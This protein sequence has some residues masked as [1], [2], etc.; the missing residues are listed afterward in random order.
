MTYS[1][2]ASANHF[3]CHFLAVFE[4]IAEEASERKIEV[5]DELFV[6]IMDFSEAERSGF[7]KAF[8]TFWELRGDSR[9]G[10]ELRVSAEKLLKGCLEHFR[11]AVTRVGRIHSVIPPEHGDEFKLRA[12]KLPKVQNSAEFRSHAALLVRDFPK[13]ASWM[14]WW[15]R[16]SHA[17]ML[18]ESERA[19]DIDI[20]E[21]MPSTT[22]AEESLHWKLYSACGRDHEFL[23]G[24]YALQGVTAYYERIYEAEQTGTPIRY[25][26]S[27]PW[28]KTAAK[29]GR[30]KP[31]RAPDIA[32]T[33]RKSKSDGRPP[34]TVKELVITPAKKKKK[35]TDP[36]F[37]NPSYPWN[38]NSCWL[39]TSLQILF[40]AL[41]RSPDEYYA[42]QEMYNKPGSERSLL[43]TIFDKLLERYEAEGST[44][45]LTTPKLRLHRD[46]I[47]QSLKSEKIIKTISAFQS[48][49]VW[50]TE[51]TRTEEVGG[52][53]RFAMAFTKHSV[54]IHECTGCKDTGGRHIQ[55][56]QAPISR[57]ILQAGEADHT[58]CNGSLDRYIENLFSIDQPSINVSSCWRNKDGVALCSGQRTDHRNLV[59]SAPLLLTIELA[60]ERTSSQDESIPLLTWDIPSVL[61]PSGLMYDVIALALIN[62][63]GSHFIARYS[64]SDGIKVYTYDGMEN[65]GIPRQEQFAFPQTSLYGHDI[66]LPKD[67][68]VYQVFYTL[69][70]GLSMQE[71]FFAERTQALAAKFNL[72][73]SS[74]T[75]DT[76]T[77]LSFANK[78]YARM[79]SEDRYWVSNSERLRGTHAEYILKVSRELQ[80]L[81]PQQRPVSPESE[82][83]TVRHRAHYISNSRAGRGALARLGEFWYPV[84]LIKQ[85]GSAWRVQYWR[86]N[87]YK[88][89]RLLAS[90]PRRICLVDIEDLVDSLWN[91]RAGR[92]K[93]R[94][95]K[96]VHA[97]S[98]PSNEEL[99]SDPSLTTYREQVDE[100]LT[101]FIEDLRSLYNHQLDRFP[102]DRFIPAL[103]WLRS[104]DKP[105][106]T[107]PIP[108]GS[109]PVTEQAQVMS[110]FESRISKNPDHRSQWIGK[111]P[112]GHAFTLYTNETIAIPERMSDIEKECIQ[113]LEEEMFEISTDAGIASHY[114]WGLDVGHHQGNWNPY[115]GLPDE[116]NHQDYG[117]I[118]DDVLRVSLSHYPRLHLPS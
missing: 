67:Y 54:E 56:T 117:S 82:E 109:I 60:N 43:A 90:T 86:E 44:T 92:R 116:W 110:W 62:S 77:V 22:N 87:H 10:A 29:I 19:M 84:R 97:H 88:D 48:L 102:D 9:N 96:W 32:E 3:E 35:N 76:P 34:D 11:A 23:E 95:G 91:D 42:L 64:S 51:L 93:I 107:T 73:F 50:F 115:S 105:L 104:T 70:D 25:G 28:K 12:L 17:T 114:Q 83:E 14:E 8:V 49:F 47:R 37:D 58:A 79:K 30:T 101:P 33:K 53:F 21:S 6:G 16:P 63:A 75:L 100:L 31:S 89:W 61:T 108:A 2:G 40:I 74:S 7:I 13:L 69:R 98:L 45:P 103:K 71:K 72:H 55:L 68:H 41:K 112:L 5:T 18:F 78:S 81:P 52:V 46:L 15:T 27:E 4:S 39:D 111:L 1:N 113:R 57:R 66:D 20:W 24:M 26:E 85:E 65:K 59:I 94:L 99:L 36:L 106:W 118:K 38:L 80:D